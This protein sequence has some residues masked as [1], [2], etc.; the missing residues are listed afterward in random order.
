MDLFLKTATVF[1]IGIIELWAAIP[2]GIAFGL[3]PLLNGVVSALGTMLGTLLVVLLGDRLRTWL[4]ERRGPGKKR[5][6]NSR[7]YRIWERYGVVG[8]GLLAPLITGAP[9]GAAIGITLGA[10]PRRLIFWCIIGII[11][12]AI[13]LTLIG[14]LGVTAFS[15]LSSPAGVE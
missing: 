1:G 5:E 13:I 4:I 9:L 7:I 11:L 6:K 15:L 2:A 3:H 12:W 14:T 8:L 10:S